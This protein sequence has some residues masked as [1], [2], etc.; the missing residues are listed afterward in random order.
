M[1]S[2]ERFIASRLNHRSGAEGESMSR[3][4]VRVAITG[5]ALGLAVMLIA[6]AVVTGF[7]REV[8]A[9]VIG[10]G[11]H[12]QMLP[13][14]NPF[15]AEQHTEITADSA[16]I[17]SLSALPHVRRVQPIASIPG[18][19][20]TD[21][22][23][24]G[25][26]L[27]GVDCRYDW[28]FFAHNM[29]AGVALNDSASGGNAAVISSSIARAM[30]LDVGDDFIVY[31][32]SGSLRAR[33][34]RVAGIYETSFSE[35]DAL[36][37][38]TDCRLVQTLNGWGP[39][40]YSS[41]E[42]LATDFS[43]LPAALG[44]V[45]TLVGNRF[46]DGGRLFRVESIQEIAPAMFDWLA[47]L[48]TNA[49]VI[50]VLMTLVSGFC[51]ISGLLII[52]LERRQMI[53]ILK[54]LG[55]ADRPIRRIFLWQAAALTFKGMAWGN[56]VGI[57]LIFVQ[58]QWHII[59]LDP[60]SYYVSYVPV[61]LSPLLWLALNA[62]VAFAALLMTVAPTHITSQVSPAEAMRFD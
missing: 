54:S 39:E 24:K 33:K 57:A 55:A 61:H 62:G 49:I 52:I 22:E 41:V 18:V 47:M 53:G 8:R 2:Y 28:D 46:S 32:M 13:Y 23:F 10:F 17:E 50:L 29:K 40:T 45:Y 15:G 36:Y 20:K 19:I 12:I 35:Y 30:K 26:V 51:M 38:M 27:K 21:E 7:K 34:L 56:A 31:F 6:V 1:P 44:E 11:G 59:P 9:Q 3:P 5:M 14:S 16:L 58:W 48:D 43:A 4:A 25:V 42:L 37:I 60:A